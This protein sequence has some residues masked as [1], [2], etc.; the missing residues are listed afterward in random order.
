MH[1]ARRTSGRRG[2]LEGC[3][4]PPPAAVSEA[5]CA[6]S[7]DRT[8]PPPTH[9]PPRPLGPS[10][11]VSRNAEPPVTSLSWKTFCAFYSRS[12]LDGGRGGQGASTVRRAP[13]PHRATQLRLPL[14]SVQFPKRRDGCLEVGQGPCPAVRPLLAAPF[15]APS[16]R[17][18]PPGRRGLRWSHARCRRR[19]R[20]R[21]SEFR[22]L[23]GRGR[24]PAG[25]GLGGGG[26]PSSR[27]RPRQ[28]RRT[29]R[30]THAS[31]EGGSVMHARPHVAPRTLLCLGEE[32]VAR[33]GARRGCHETE[34]NV[35]VFGSKALNS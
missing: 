33:H 21:Q 8:P 30:G 34:V 5:V 29:P 26:L 16:S 10:P 27:P 20:R 35:S 24:H 32:L 1:S 2:F 11:R 28:G 15:P 31:S 22:V 25:G 23:P 14:R 9:P 4:S 7:S 6:S 17:Q 18:K 3:S 13:A 12:A 19:G